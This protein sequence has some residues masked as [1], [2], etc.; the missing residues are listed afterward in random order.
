MKKILI[1]NLVTTK[2]IADV[3]GTSSQN[4]H[5]TYINNKNG[6]DKSDMLRALSY[7]AFLMEAEVTPYELKLAKEMIMTIREVNDK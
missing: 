5:N 2:Q 6:K 7:G 4:I 1:E 3:I